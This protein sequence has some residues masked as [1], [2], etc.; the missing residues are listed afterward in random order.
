M[1]LK[2]RDLWL[3]PL[4]PFALLSIAL[5]FAFAGIVTVLGGDQ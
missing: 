3:L 2:L 4:L 5:G 1:R